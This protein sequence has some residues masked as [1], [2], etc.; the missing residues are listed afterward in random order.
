M[1]T[2]RI[3]CLMQGLVL[4]SKVFFFCA[5]CLFSLLFPLFI[6]EA[7]EASLGAYPRFIGDEYNRK[8]MFYE[9]NE[10]LQWMDI[11]HSEIADYSVYGPSTH[12]L[13]ENP[14]ELVMQVRAIYHDKNMLARLDK[15]YMSQLRKGRSV[16]VMEMEI[17]FHMKEEEYAITKVTVY[18]DAHEVI[19]MA[20]REE[21]FQKIPFDS[22][23]SAL[24]DIGEKYIDYGKKN[25]KR[26]A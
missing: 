23:V 21:V 12:V 22:F 2:R 9:R 5:L 26:V 25:T 14:N 16:A 15:M 7:E 4:R 13:A 1:S 20:K 8:H 17:H 6:A 11:F 18:D 3:G 24:Y 19:A 10:V